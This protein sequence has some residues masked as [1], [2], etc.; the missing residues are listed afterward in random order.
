MDY[1]A[2]TYRKKNTIII[3]LLEGIALVLILAL[4]E[5]KFPY[6][7]LWIMVIF[8]LQ[9]LVV[10]LSF[11]NIGRQVQQIENALERL[12]RGKMNA[13]ILTPR[14]LAHTAIKYVNQLFMQME[15][16]TLYIEKIGSRQ[17]ES[18]SEAK[19]LHLSTN[20][21]LGKALSEMRNK[22]QIFQD[23]EQKR[24]WSTEGL[25]QFSEVLRNHTDN[26]EEFSN[27]VIRHLVKYLKCNQGSLFIENEQDGEI[28]LEL[29][30]CYAYDKRKYQEKKFKTGQGLVGQ[31]AFEKQTISITDLPQ[32]YVHITSGLG[33]ATPTHL[34]IVP[35]MVNHEFHGVIELASFHKL[36]GYQITFLEKIAESIA[37]TLGTV[38]VTMQTQNLLDNS[39]ELTAELRAREEEMRHHLE[40]LTAA[41]HEMQ[42]KQSELQWV[43]KAMDN[44]LLTATFDLEGNLLT[45]NDK[46]TL[47]STYSIQE[48]HQ[49]GHNLFVIEKEDPLFWQD[50]QQGVVKSG[51]FKLMTQNGEEK[52][53]NASFTP[54]HA[55]EGQQKKVLMLGTDI[56][57][58]KLVLE[59]LSLVAHNTDNSVIITDNQG[60]IEFVNEGFTALTGY[61]QEEVVGR[62][63]GHLLQGPRTDSETIKRIRKQIKQGVP[64]YEEILNYRKDGRSYWISLMINPVKNEK[65]YIEKFVSIQS[66]VTKIKEATLDYTY[67][68]EAIGRSNAVVEFDIQGNIIDVNAIFLSVTGYEKEELIG[69]PYEYLLPEREKDK[70]QVQMMWDN[71]KEGTFFSG[72]FIQKSKEGKDLWLSG[73]FNPIFDLEEKLQRIL[74]FAQFTTHEKEKQHELSSM[75]EALNNSVMTLEMDTQGSLKKGNA[76]FLQTFGYKRSEISRKTIEDLIKDPRQIHELVVQLRQ[77]D[78]VTCTLTLT[79]KEGE[80]R[81]YQ[82][83]FHAMR[84]LERQ[85]HRILII[86]IEG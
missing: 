47:L 18:Q 4:L 36:E 60:Y 67:K 22:M 8:L 55:D 42:I 39:H 57:E 61:G 66:D 81:V 24:N 33:E 78:S 84:N 13:E 48:L 72:E 15:D 3:L 16:A 38:K 30:A 69:K 29:V 65:G 35:L 25:A 52:W 51:D 26:L 9:V 74:M 19:L 58:K 27:Q 28:Y 37:A 85:L 6:Q 31:C 54:M 41:Q 73:T 80:D 83:T 1:R 21:H 2:N 75:L 46:L 10:Y 17:Q 14:G 7:K 34:V 79:T 20:D 70:P 23:E 59:K 53:M 45:A 40:T 11:R 43:F 44:S 77:E 32:N 71:L 86:L 63:P 62:K 82:A 12:T 76:Q 68:L 49:L 64:F 50:I 5:I 56:T